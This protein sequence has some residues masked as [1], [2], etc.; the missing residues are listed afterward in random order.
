[1]RGCT[2]FYSCGD[3]IN[4]TKIGSTA[5]RTALPPPTILG[6]RTGLRPLKTLFEGRT[7]PWGYIEM[8]CINGGYC[9][10]RH[11]GRVRPIPCY[12]VL[13][14]CVGTEPNRHDGKENAYI[15]N[16]NQPGNGNE[17]RNGQRYVYVTFVLYILRYAIFTIR[18]LL[19]FGPYVICCHSPL[20][21]HF[22]LIPESF[23]DDGWIGPSTCQFSVDK[24]HI[25]S[26][27]PS[28]VGWR[29]RGA[30]NR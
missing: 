13:S 3:E 5:A 25:T 14:S 29:Q 11:C 8:A 27:Q 23:G 4:I 7:T 22:D 26:T 21:Q 10:M 12:I 18:N 20:S 2:I 30:I 1:M 28:F 16:N 9:A 19:E 15:C 6:E 17:D 24:V